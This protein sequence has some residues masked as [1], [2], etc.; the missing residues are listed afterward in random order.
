M[1]WGTLHGF[2]LIFENIVIRLWTKIQPKRI[3]SKWSLNGVK[4]IFTFA[5]VCFAWIFF[6]ANSVT[7]AI[8][9]INHLMPTE[10][11]VLHITRF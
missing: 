9:A 11:S 7:D 6:R 1:I 5:L 2:Y 3:N 4:I 8:Y 10:L